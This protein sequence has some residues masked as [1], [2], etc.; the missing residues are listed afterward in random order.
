MQAIWQVIVHLFLASQLHFQV[1]G[2]PWLFTIECEPL[3]TSGNE[4]WA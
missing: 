4:T 1:L 2:G 3:S